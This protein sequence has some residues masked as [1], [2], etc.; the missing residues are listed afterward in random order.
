MQSILSQDGGSVRPFVVV[1][2]PDPD[3]DLVRELRGD[4]RLD[5]IELRE[6][7]LP[8]A[9]REGFKAVRS[10]FFGTLDDDDVLLPGALAKRFE[11]LER[12]PDRAVVVTN[13]FRRTRHSQVLH[14][15]DSSR[16]Q[17]DPAGALL[18]RNWLLPGSWLARTDRVD[19]DLFEHM[20]FAVECTYLALRFSTT[21]PMVFLDEPTVVW[22]ENS[23]FSLSRSEGYFLSMVDGLR[24]LLTLPLPRHLR[25]GLARKL[26]DAMHERADRSYWAGRSRDAWAWHL[27]SVA[28]LDGFRYLDFTFRLLLGQRDR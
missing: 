6:A 2:G 26:T 28:R 7:S 4:P 17:A 16:V 20:P 25:R 21:Y 3:P 9:F 10:P 5:L 19:S 23:P 15:T 12:N 27:R 14:V 13:G 24:R 22:R 18:E 11:C 8:G 1:N